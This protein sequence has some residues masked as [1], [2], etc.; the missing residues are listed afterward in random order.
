MYDTF[1]VWIT[2]RPLKTIEFCEHN[3]LV[4]MT[5]I[6]ES[7]ESGVGSSDPYAG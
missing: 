5:R 1:N 2:Q 4:K 6:K 7:C 3:I